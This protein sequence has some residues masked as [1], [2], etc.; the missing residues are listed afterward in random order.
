[1]QCFDEN[2][3]LEDPRKL[4]YSEIVDKEKVRQERKE[5]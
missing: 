2:K 1:M 4:K 5:C 3:I